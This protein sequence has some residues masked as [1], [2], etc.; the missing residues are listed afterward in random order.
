MNMSMAT[1][2]LRTVITILIFSKKSATAKELYGSIFMGHG[3]SS[4]ALYNSKLVKKKYCD[5]NQKEIE[6][7]GN[8]RVCGANV[9]N[10]AYKLN[11]INLNACYLNG[12]NLK[13]LSYKFY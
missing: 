6:Y 2:C 11:F 1:P 12:N 4:G 7:E 8:V 9:G 5:V 10:L 3:A 13:K